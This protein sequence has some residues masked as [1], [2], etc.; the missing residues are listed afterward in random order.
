ML[1]VICVSPTQSL[2]RE[3]RIYSTP[4]SSANH[5]NDSPPTKHGQ[6]VL[7][8]P[9]QTSVERKR[10]HFVVLKYLLGKDIE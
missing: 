1:A 7:G 8:M 3:T 9:I 4:C 6:A 5:M 2:I 10:I